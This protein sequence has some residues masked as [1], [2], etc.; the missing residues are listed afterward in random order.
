VT[1]AEAPPVQRTAGNFI[2]GEERGAAGGSTFVKLSPASGEPLS[3]VARSDRRDVEAAVDAAR[4]A[5]PDWARRT[6]AERGAMLRRIAQLLERDADEIAAVI[7]AETGK[8]PKEARGEVGAAIEQGYFVAGEG[9]RFYGRTTTSAIPGR[10]AMTVRQP[11][12]VAGLI[13]A[14]NTPIANVAW[15]VFPA[16]MCGNAVVLKAPEDT[17]ET[18][19]AFARLGAEAGLPAGILNVV[20]GYGDEA[21]QPLVEHPDV[22]VVSFTG[23]TAVGRLI[24]R[25]GGERLRRRL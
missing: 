23:S 5:Q 6:V 12:G 11:L 22:A 21:G 4:A 17:P 24:A 13:I 19:L 15:K 8:A 2:A 7:A 18:P 9:R 10:Q 14:A 3:A 25:I 20:Q 1:T 16:L